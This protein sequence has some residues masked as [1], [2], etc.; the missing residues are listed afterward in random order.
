M[1][2]LLICRLLLLYIDTVLERMLILVLQYNAGIGKDSM[3]PSSGGID[4]RETRTIFVLI[5]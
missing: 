2:P 1:R 5:D 3:A 4:E